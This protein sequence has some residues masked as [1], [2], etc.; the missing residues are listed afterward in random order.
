MTTKQVATLLIAIGQWSCNGQTKTTE[1]T[2]PSIPVTVLYKQITSLTQSEIK[3]L[4]S[5]NIDFQFSGGCYAFSSAKNA[6][7]SNGEAHSDNLPQKVDKSFP[8]QGFYLVINQNEFSKINSTVL[9]CK[10]YLVNTTDSLIKLDASD[11]RLY[12]VA[13]ALNGK[14]EWTPISYLPSSDCGNSYHTIA[15]DKDEYWSFDIPVF[16]GKIKTKLRY[17]LTIIEYKKIISNEIVAYLNKGQ[18]DDKNKEGHRG[19]NIM[20]PYGE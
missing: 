11:S 10:L 12:I 14:K 4:D 20:D 13:E 7:E 5:V 15:L 19:N 1:P 18:F 2:E 9:G 6:E 8:R 16:K 17:T 3:R